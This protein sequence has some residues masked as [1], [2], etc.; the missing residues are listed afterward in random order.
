MACYWRE[1]L[2]FTFFTLFFKINLDDKLFYQSNCTERIWPS[3][4]WCAHFVIQTKFLKYQPKHMFNIL[5]LT[6]KVLPW[7]VF[8]ADNTLKL[9][10]SF[11]HIST[12]SEGDIVGGWNSILFYISGNRFISFKTKSWMHL[13]CIPNLKHSNPSLKGY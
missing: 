6:I 11:I 12:S 1:N 9:Y 7:M 10:L 8:D 4:L 2:F 13:I 3:I 5:N